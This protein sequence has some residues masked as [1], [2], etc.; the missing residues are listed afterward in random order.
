MMPQVR[1]SLVF[2]IVIASW[3]VA[4]NGHSADVVL[5]RFDIGTGP[6]AV[7]M[8]DASEDTEIAGPQA[9]YAADSGELYLLD[10]V[11]GRVLRFDPKQPAAATRSLGL[12]SDLQPT[13]LVVLRND[14]F[15]WDGEVRALRPTGPDDAPTRGLE[16]FQTRA[17]DDNFTI[18]AFAQMGSQKLGRR[19]GPF[20]REHP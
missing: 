16:E 6:N 2:A 19:D 9:L 10:Q 11:N 7:G 14:I 12:P 1:D 15:V 4:T 17:A 8:V 5:K 20:R 18:S 13:D 3:A